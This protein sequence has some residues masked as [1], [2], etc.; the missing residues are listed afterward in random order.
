MMTYILLI[1]I[2][3]I[4]F[5]SFSIVIFIKKIYATFLPQALHQG[6]ALCTSSII[7]AFQD[8]ILIGCLF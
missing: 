3:I 2:L 7:V 5:P 1:N 4:Y 6:F 8:V